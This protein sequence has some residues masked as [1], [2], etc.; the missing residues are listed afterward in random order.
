MEVLLLI[1]LIIILIIVITM[2][3]ETSTK[4]DD[5]QSELNKIKQLLA[6]SLKENNV[7]IE[8]KRTTVLQKEFESNFKV[9]E[10]PKIIVEPILESAP[11]VEK[12]EEVK[13]ESILQTTATPDF[14]NEYFEESSGPSFFERNPDLEKFIG[15]NLIN[16][17]GIAVLV[18]GISFFVKFAI[19]QN[20]INEIGRVFIG[21]LCG[22]ILIGIAHK[23]HN[24]YRSFSSV[25]VGGGL[26][27][28]YFTIAFA[29]HQYHLLSQ[30]AS[31][32]IMIV[33]TV[34]AVLLSIFYDRIEL[35][36]L[37]T[38]GGFI[39]PFLVSN[40][41]GNYV[42][43]FSYLC[44]LN[45]GL[46]AL[47]YAKRWRILNFI[48]FFFTVIIYGAWLNKEIAQTLIHP[49]GAFVF[50]TLFYMMFVIMNVIHH[51]TR[52]SAFKAFDFIILLSI[53]LAYYSAGILI[54]QNAEMENYKG[55]FTASLGVV[56]LLL[57]YIFYQKE[58]IDKNFVYLLIGLTLS[59]IS[60]AGPVQFKG[61]FITLFWSTEMVVLFW[62]YQRT[63]I[64]LL[65]ITSLLVSVLMLI[66]LMIDLHEV[67]SSNNL[68]Q[69][70]INKGFITCVFS[71]IA[72]CCNY[73]LLKKETDTNY[74]LGIQNQL[75]K[76]VY[77][78]VSVILLFIAGMLEINYQFYSRYPASGLE[79]I[80]FQLY[81]ISFFFILF[82]IL[83]KR[84]FK[85]NNAFRLGLT[86]FIFL[87]YLL[88]TINVFRTE[89]FLLS[90]QQN[91]IHFLMQWISVIILVMLIINT[92]QFVRKDAV[93][94]EKI[95]Q[96]CA[97]IA[98]TAFVF[99][100][101]LEIYHLYVWLNY[102]DQTSITYADNLYGKAGL[103]IVWGLSSF[104]I[105]WVGMKYSLKLLRVLALALFGIT[106]IKLFVYDISNIPIGGKIAAFILLG[107]LL[108]IV[109]FMYQRL[110]KLIIDN[111]KKTD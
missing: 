91:K 78:S 30:T 26:T 65:K 46:I 58:N 28:F 9:I 76:I 94:F 42:V 95:F 87:F 88:N 52:G 82:I 40:G 24:S 59:Y 51:V 38:I 35:G 101:S 70:L 29:Y 15:E 104:A 67:Y 25:L 44:I 97:G 92:I 19:D 100:L 2:K 32:I 111:E 31:F 90:T 17:I 71:S 83:S 5:L 79:H 22:A 16:K 105:I 41:A 49:T 102:V 13:S 64:L 96:Q 93:L 53:N 6:K 34:F 72:L 66:S 10:Q 55:L 108:L 99:I 73:F 47:A 109:S 80:Y 84:N 27:V 7:P 3:N 86:L 20:W 110:K 48:G 33:I 63:S 56:N 77:L 14:K 45:A 69:I 74:L 23:L 8:E 4:F 75:V 85:I 36:I 81:F 1:P 103:S 21:L 54:F 57:A 106:I 68:L 11:I 107:I 60:L 37:A 50:A 18:L 12:I 43:L 62:L 89:T 61:H 39:T 98:A